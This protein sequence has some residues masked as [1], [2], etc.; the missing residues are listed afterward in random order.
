MKQ[1]LK[2]ALR[3]ENGKHIFPFFWQ[4]GEDDETLLRELHSI[5]D[6]GIRSLCVESRPHEGFGGEEWFEDMALILAECEKLG[7]EF[8]LL[9][10]KHFPTGRANGLMMKKYP[11]HGKREMTAHVVDV[12]GPVKDCGIMCDCPLKY[13]GSELIAVVACQRVPGD[14]DQMMTGTAVDL[15]DKYDPENDMVFFDLPEGQWRI[16]V[17]FHRPSKSDFI[18]MLREESVQVLIEAVYEPHYQRFGKYFG[19]TFRG[20]FSDEPYIMHGGNIPKGNDNAVHQLFPWNENVK[21]ELAK[22]CPDWKLQLPK[23]WFPAEGHSR[24][25]V[26]YMD[27][28][29]KL[30]AKHFAWQLG[31]W[32]RAHGVEYIG[33]IIEDNGKDTNFSSGGHFFRSLDGQDMAGIDVVLCQIMPGMNDDKNAVPCGYKFADNKMFHYGL[34]KMAAS[35]SH[36]QPQK[37]GR[38]MC[39]IYGAYGW[40]EG[41][42]MMKWL[43]DHMLVRGINHYVPHAFSPKCP[44]PDCPPHFYNGGHNPEFYSFGTLMGYMERVCGILSDGRHHASAAIL[45]HAQAE[46]SGKPYMKI[47]DPAKVLLDNQLDFDIVPEDYLDNCSVSGKRMLLNQEDYRVFI[48]PQ[49]T[50]LPRAVVEKLH[51]FAIQ[52]L[53]VWCIGSKPTHTCEG[54]P[55]PADMLAQFE[56]MELDKLPA[57]MRFRGFADV[58]AVGENTK[59]LRVYHYSR[60]GGHVVMVTNEGIHGEVK[61]KLS[62][63]DFKGGDFVRYDALENKAVRDN[64]KR[65]IEI[66]LPVYGSELLFFGDIEMDGIFPAAEKTWENLNVKPDAWKVSFC[67]PEDY[68]PGDHCP[69]AFGEEET[70]TELFN[71]IRKKKK[72][73]GFVRYET[74]FTVPGEG[75]DRREYGLDLGQ[76]GEVAY[77]WV[78]GQKAGE[79]II[80]PY[81]F[82]FTAIPGKRVKLCVV[83]T[84][85]LGYEQQD[86]FSSYMPFEPVGLLG[87]VTVEG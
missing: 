11:Q 29:T 71:V 3:N 77:V 30:Y 83:T 85:H 39:E 65:E 73:A 23:L 70:V 42:N 9:D 36:I 69:A 53:P 59:W 48:V 76:V 66:S 33:H 58:V 50:M 18:D 40:A 51:S 79:R 74:E 61:A 19:K 13:P 41:L 10:D 68:K 81:R 25:R 4:H 56:L 34:A 12:S 54:D 63:R 87:P 86:H 31:N 84:S 8:W 35:H 67:A 32:S 75:M 47:D 14:P 78:D 45:Y 26:H 57:A 49:A 24:I 43:T 62:L 72:F 37:K 82:R 16:F 6:C 7:M 5:Y 15:T 2:A 64:A 44:D 28:V 60:N 46:W 52:G 20:Y 55:I 27:V 1:K 80:P 38:A 22:V 17:I 21:R